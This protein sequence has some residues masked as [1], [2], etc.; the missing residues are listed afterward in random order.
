MAT[1]WNGCTRSCVCS[2]IEPL[3]KAQHFWGLVVLRWSQ[4]W[5][6]RYLC[7]VRCWLIHFLKV[8]YSV[9][10]QI[11]CHTG[12]RQKCENRGMCVKNCACTTASALRKWSFHKEWPA[13]SHPFPMSPGAKEALRIFSLLILH[14]LSDCSLRFKQTCLWGMSQAVCEKWIYYIMKNN[15]QLQYAN[16]ANNKTSWV[17]DKSCVCHYRLS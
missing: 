16:T 7:I 10:T 8:H 5:H 1:G 17:H 15:Q 12:A 4:I 2:S 3:R 13:R 9:L 14:H 11:K 6:E